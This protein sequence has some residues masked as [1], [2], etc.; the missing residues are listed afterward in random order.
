MLRSINTECL[1]HK[2][3][4][5]VKIDS[6]LCLKNLFRITLRGT[7]VSFIPV[8]SRIKISIT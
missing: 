3:N 6:D 8:L 4:R 5:L 1:V 2:R 7:K